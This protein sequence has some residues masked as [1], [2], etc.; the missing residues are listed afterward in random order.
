[1]TESDEQIAYERL[2]R[3]TELNRSV[4]F[5]VVFRCGLVV[6]AHPLDLPGGLDIWHR[7]LHGAAARSC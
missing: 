4:V 1:M 7:I 5:F 2:F 6:L 3:F